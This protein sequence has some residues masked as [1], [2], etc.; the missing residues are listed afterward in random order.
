MEGSAPFISSYGKPLLFLTCRIF[1]PLVYP[2]CLFNRQLC[3]IGCFYSVSLMS[4][5]PTLHLGFQF[6][7]FA[8]KQSH[9]LIFCDLH[10]YPH[11]LCFLDYSYFLEKSSPS[12][13]PLSNQP[14]G[15]FLSLFLLSNDLFYCEVYFV[16]C[17]LYL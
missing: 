14:L 13:C 12:P 8:P 3:P 2:P 6:Q 1:L 15:L 10:I 17:S 9:L 16:S 5:P 11:D 4:N 7:A